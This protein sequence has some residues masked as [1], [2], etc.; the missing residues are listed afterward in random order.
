MRYSPIVFCL[1]TVLLVGDLFAANPDY[2]PNWAVGDS[3]K[4]R[5]TVNLYRQPKSGEGLVA[6]PSD[7]VYRYVVT[8]VGKNVSGEIEHPGNL[9]NAEKE[10][11]AKNIVRIRVIPVGAGSEWILSINLTNLALMQV[12]E[13]VRDRSDTIRHG[14][15]FDDAWMAKLQQYSFRMIHDFPNIPSSDASRLIAPKVSGTPAFT[16]TA[17]FGSGQ[18]TVTMTRTDPASSMEHKTTIV[19]EEEQKWWKSA[20]TEL[21]GEVKISGVLEP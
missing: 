15:P 7:F 17:T 2:A 20:I 21:G 1:L 12:E 5:Y 4:V 19:W 9:P 13:V 18:V 3:W 8:S 14:N 11:I 10:T 16:Q 6:T